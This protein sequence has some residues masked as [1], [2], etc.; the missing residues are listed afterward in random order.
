[1]NRAT[2]IYLDLVRPIA[3]LAVLIEL[4]GG[5]SPQVETGLVSERWFEVLGFACRCIFGRS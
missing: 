3:A 1:M 2:S 5:N 4:R